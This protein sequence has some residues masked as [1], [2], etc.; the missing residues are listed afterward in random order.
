[1]SNTSAPV[2]A[3]SATA[4]PTNPG[5]TA[6]P[7]AAGGQSAQASKTPY[8]TIGGKPYT[9]EEL[10]AA[11]ETQASLGSRLGELDAKEASVAKLRDKSK[12][13]EAMRELGHDPDELAVERMLALK[14]EDEM[15]PKDRELA[16]YK[17]KA[18]AYE[19]E[20]AER[21]KEA[22][23]AKGKE[24]QARQRQ[25][26]EE[27]IVTAAAKHGLP[28]NPRAMGEVFTLMDRAAAHNLELPEDE[29]VQM[30]KQ[31][32][33]RE[34]TAHIKDLSPEGLL[35]LLPRDTQK[36]LLKVLTNQALAP[37]ARSPDARP[38]KAADGGSNEPKPAWLTKFLDF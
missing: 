14:A 32:L 31:D 13:A 6:T 4:A 30:V 1:M 17:A 21:L 7:Q 35:S 23:E 10:Q 38:S 26:Q 29:A 16:Q 3:P 19:R 27:R 18:E 25:M 33:S 8:T 15:D 28:V 24:L 11:L 37:S 20:Q 5:E 34:M 12:W 36:A 2:A 9:M 22:E